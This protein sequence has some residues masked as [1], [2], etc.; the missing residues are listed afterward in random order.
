MWKCLLEH[1]ASV[2]VQA[3]LRSLLI[4][5]WGKCPVSFEANAH[6][7]PASSCYDRKKKN[8]DF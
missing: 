4:F 8:A 3:R 2:S 6:L 5:A 7:C 1:R